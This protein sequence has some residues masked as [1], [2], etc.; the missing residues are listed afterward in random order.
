[1][2]E[3]W[4]NWENSPDWKSNL[5][6]EWTRK[7]RALEQAHKPLRGKNKDAFL[8]KRRALRVSYDEERRRLAELHSAV[9]PLAADRQVSV[10]DVASRV[11]RFIGEQLG[12]L[13][14]RKDALQKELASVE[15]QVSSVREAVMRQFGGATSTARGGVAKAVRKGSRALSGETR[16]KMAEAAR[17]RWA[18]EKK[19]DGRRGNG[20]L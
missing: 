1:L 6:D 9:P 17:R 20:D 16:A 4:K 15:A 7:E 11:A 19:R 2:A 12:A 18:K 5:K 3:E 14:N 10:D 13:M 8:A